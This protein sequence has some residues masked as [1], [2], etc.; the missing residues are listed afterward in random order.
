M[1][2]GLPA[3]PNYQLQ[4]QLTYHRRSN[5]HHYPWGKIRRAA[6]T[7]RNY[8]EGISRAAEEAF[9]VAVELIEVLN[10]D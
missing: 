6:I 9:S 10:E 1:R 3:E 5:P 4:L 7:L 8:C 2:H